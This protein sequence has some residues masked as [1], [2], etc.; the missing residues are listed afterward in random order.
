MT[1]GGTND[2]AP[3]LFVLMLL[4]V[5][6]KDVKRGLKAGR[7]AARIPTCV[8]SDAARLLVIA[9]GKVNF[10]RSYSF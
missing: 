3:Q 6:R 5:S 4:A 1:R 9:V 7:H 2:C 10:M 8:Q